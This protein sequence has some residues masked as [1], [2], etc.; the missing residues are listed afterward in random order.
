MGDAPGALAGCC[1]PR[2][3]QGR[4]RQPGLAQIVYTA[5]EAIL[6]RFQLTNV[7]L[8]FANFPAELIAEPLHGSHHFSPGGLQLRRGGEGNVHYNCK[9]GQLNAD[10]ASDG[11]RHQP[12]G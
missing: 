1:R 11:G 3:G 5:I 10:D 9:G 7:C 2:L 6:T 8:E 12:W 4:R